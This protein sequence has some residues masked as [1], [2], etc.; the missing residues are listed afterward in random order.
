MLRSRLF[1]K[2]FLTFAAVNLLAAFALLRATLGWLE[3]RAYSEAEGQLKAAA[4]LMDEAYGQRLAEGPSES[5]Q[6]NLVEMG[7][8]SGF[9]LTLIDDQGRVL[10]DSSQPNLAAVN[11]MESHA[12]RTEVVRA[13]EAGQGI[14]RRTSA[15]L[16]RSFVYLA[17]RHQDEG[18]TLGVVRAALAVSVIKEQVGLLSQRLWLYGMIVSAA[19]LGVTYF[20]VQRIVHPVLVLNKAAHAI[21]RGDY[22]QRAFVPTRD[23]LGTLARS[24]NRM[25]R[26]LEDQFT[27]LR[28]SG[29]RQST[30]LGGMI[31]GVIATNAQQHVVLANKAAGKLFKFLP[32]KVEGRPLIE[33]IRNHTLQEAL[34][35]VLAT[36][37]PERLDI[38]WQGAPPLSLSVQVTPL[39]GSPA[40]GAVIVLH[41]TT[42]LRRLEKLRQEF[43]A[44]V[45]HELKTPLSSI[46]AYT[47]TLLDGA[48]HDEQHA[49]QFLRRI[50]EQADRLHALI[51]DMLSLARIESD[52]QTFELTNIPVGEAAAA[53]LRDYAPQA[54]SRRVELSAESEESPRSK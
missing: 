17:R 50:E 13:M 8:E 34:T 2:L 43:V 39:P 12:H 19:L 36:G 31:E 23:E 51:Q 16:D 40:S 20:V 22:T 25:S 29:E 24:F 32:D 27:E 35:K 15:S 47:E 30:V 4:A 3:D 37:Q 48:L 53:C 5:L 21:S 7:R 1:W 26:D 10:A 52:Q 33:L 38:Q 42:E 9:R 46:K 6:A 44:N 54:E 49:M 45:S 11:Q 18:R 14:N 41:D 28:S